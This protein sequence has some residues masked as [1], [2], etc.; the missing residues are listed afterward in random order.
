[1][2]PTGTI[3]NLFCFLL[4]MYE[5]HLWNCVTSA[6]E[7]T[8]ALQLREDKDFLQIL[9]KVIIFDFITVIYIC[10]LYLYNLI[11]IML[12]NNT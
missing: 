3:L 1:M 4:T 10:Y 7:G 2:E 12:S 8:F 5:F 9:F 11:F 6:F